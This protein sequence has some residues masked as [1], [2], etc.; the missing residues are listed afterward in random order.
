[1]ITPKTEEL[2]NIFGRAGR[3][4]E[5]SGAMMYGPDLGDWPIWAVDVVDQI[6]LCES[7]EAI[8]RMEAEAGER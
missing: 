3:V 6:R 1:V 4:R 2:L 7:Q 5:A 8:A